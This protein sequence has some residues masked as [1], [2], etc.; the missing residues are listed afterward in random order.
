MSFVYGNFLIPVLLIA[1]GICYLFWIK[2][3][4]VAN[5]VKNYWFY[6]ISK[7]SKWALI[8]FS[9]GVTMLSLSLLDLRGPSE[10]IKAEIP[11]QRTLILIDV[12]LS[13][14]AED[15][16]PNRLFK[17]IQV[18]KHFVRKAA[19]HSISVNIFSDNS[20]QLI[21]FSKDI[22]LID[23]RLNA[24]KDYNIGRGGS[25]IRKAIQESVQSFRAF[26]K[27]PSKTKGNILILS[28]SEETASDWELDLPDG[29]TIAYV[30]VGTRK[31]AR[32][33][34]RGKTG[35]LQGYKKFNNSEVVSKLDEAELKKLA[36]KIGNFKYWVLT[37]YSIPTE[38]L[39]SYFSKLHNDKYA[40]AD[41]IIR[42]VL[43]EYIVVPA[44][45]LIII[46]FILRLKKS[47]IIPVLLIF[48]NIES[49]AN[50]Q[51]AK[52]VDI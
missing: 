50:T 27:D 51:D 12:S 22:D 2:E 10:N 5:W 9:L 40:M 42:P 14:M 44:I 35:D 39:L 17:A 32:I 18:A 7:S 6:T 23:A 16:R 15:I 28:D 13:M 34:I 46:S 25:N 4:K 36:D 38:E 31:G 49:F 26:Y 48:F 8:F 37:S 21:P 43:M 52:E 3:K 33:P 41:T 11:V 45:L 30:A 20:K 19:G 47:Y 24:L 1:I 29:V